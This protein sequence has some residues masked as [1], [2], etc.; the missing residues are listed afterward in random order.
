[1][2]LS[3]TRFRNP[4]ISPHW[5]A[6]AC[7][8]PYRQDRG[9]ANIAPEYARVVDCRGID[10]H[11]PSAG[12]L[13]EIDGLRIVMKTK[14]EEN[15]DAKSEQTEAPYQ[16]KEAYFRQLF[17]GSPDAI[18][19]ADPRGEVLEANAS[20]ERIFQYSPEEAKG[21][22]INELVAPPHLAGEADELSER[23]QKGEVVQKDV[24][25]RRK[26]GAL[27]VTSVLAYPIV[28]DGGIVG[29]CGIYRDIT[30]QKR[31]EETLNK[32]SRAVEQTAENIFI[33]D[34]EGRIEYVNPAFE[35]LTE[36]SSAEVLGNTPR[37]LKS[38]RQD[39][40]FYTALWETIESGR[41]FRGTLINRKKSGKVYYEE[42]TITPV[43]DRQG[44]ITNFISTGKDITDRMELE[45]RLLQAQKLEAVGRLAG[46]VAHDFNN[47]LTAVIGYGELLASRLGSDDPLR[48]MAQE[49]I[50]GGQRGAAL[51]RQ[52][53]AFSRKQ[54]LQPRVIDL[55]DIILNIRNM[56]ERLIPE[57]IKLVTRPG[58]AIGSVKADPGQIEQVIV[59]LVIN[60][61][62]AMPNGGALTI[63]TLAVDL[64]NGYAFQ[65]LVHTRGRYIMLAVSD[66]GVGMDSETQSHV[67][68]PFFT[69]KEHGGSGLGL[70]T[71]YGIVN[72]SGG[73][74]WLYSEL[75]QGTTVKVY[76]P[77]CEEA[78]ETDQQEAPTPRL[79]AGAET[80][81]LVE[82]NSQVREL[83]AEI[84]RTRG[85]RV[86]EASGGEAALR[87]A[88]EHR[89]RSI[90]LLIT[91][92]VMPEMSGPQLA[93]LMA[94]SGQQVKVLY[95]SGYTDNWIVH[96]GVLEGAT[97]FL[98][99]PFTPGV[100]A[101]KVREVLD[102]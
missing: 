61:R 4:P 92:V 102:S 15:I 77:S 87:I 54:V 39:P 75:G 91:D 2:T 86:L 45:E 76:L 93:Q 66:T 19:M 33:T 44:K 58:T 96:H 49:I 67:F 17:E 31:T 13:I 26:D 28:I 90:D 18:V 64:D 98:Q 65:P 56:L 72:Q 81:L 22:L 62:D 6:N 46:G 73:T 70:A 34:R 27:I 88:R 89:G 14:R 83:A 59:N 40:E 5:E 11:R 94:A 71:V 38:G 3:H 21:R 42:K 53:L 84:L 74:V 43:K 52:L 60:A 78:A 10:C 25:R 80:V 47:L 37:I 8:V 50:R 69:T 36:Y 57:N 41:P 29:F 20:F 85:Y 101:G 51:A 32:L 23:T 55:N 35:E 79:S 1:M 24:V 48:Q 9:A 30:E 7:G 82:D 16:H 12:R 97:S 95:I 99:K 100:L 68:E 63:E